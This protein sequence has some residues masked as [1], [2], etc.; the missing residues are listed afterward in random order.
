[1]LKIIPPIIAILMTKSIAPTTSA[2]PVLRKLSSD[3]NPA[4]FTAWSAAVISY[5]RLPTTDRRNH[6]HGTP[7]IG[8]SVMSPIIIEIDGTIEKIIELLITY[9]IFSS[10]TPNSFALF[11]A[12]LK[13]NT[14]IPKMV[15]SAKIMRAYNSL[16][17]S[18]S[19]IFIKSPLII[20]Y[21]HLYLTTFLR[22]FPY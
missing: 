22:T 4:A 21:R 16:L 5:G 2:V 13:K 1:M 10:G 8:T 15:A 6:G 20:F 19:I 7:K 12:R 9:F 18:T 3:E 17:L 14:H 11:L